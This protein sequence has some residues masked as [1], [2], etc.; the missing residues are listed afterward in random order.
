MSASSSGWWRALRTAGAWDGGFIGNVP[1]GTA[2]RAMVGVVLA[3]AI[4]PGVDWVLLEGLVEPITGGLFGGVG[5][6]ICNFLTRGN[7]KVTLLVGSR[8]DSEGGMGVG[9]CVSSLVEESF[10]QFG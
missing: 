7:W 1:A 10:Q 6:G 2:C 5:V 8:C 4:T 3:L 9:C